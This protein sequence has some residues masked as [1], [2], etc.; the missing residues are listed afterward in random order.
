MDED[1]GRLRTLSDGLAIAAKAIGALEELAGYH[2]KTNKIFDA[3]SNRSYV[4]VIQG[5]QISHRL[6][7]ERR[8]HKSAPAPRHPRYGARIVRR[9]LMTR[10]GYTPYCG[11]V[12]CGKTPRTFF[13]LNTEQFKCPDC[14]WW[15][16]FPDGFISDYKRTWGL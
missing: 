11:N 1:Q 4:K 6:V 10:K 13:D 15:S 14:G 3:E 16:G 9:N 7:E 12:D 5:Q 8:G 2:D